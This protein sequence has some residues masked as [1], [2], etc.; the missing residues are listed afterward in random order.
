MSHL[1]RSRK[2]VMIAPRS[3]PPPPTLATIASTKMDPKLFAV[4]YK[5]SESD[6]HQYFQTFDDPQV[7]LEEGCPKEVEDREE[8]WVWL[9]S[10]FQEPHN[11]KAKANKISWE[12]KT[13]IHHS[14]SKPFS[15]R[16]KAW[17]QRGSKFLEI[18]IFADVYIRLRDKLVESLHATMMENT[19]GIE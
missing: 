16:M 9:C 13:F 17:P 19:I 5:Q 15:Y 18:D 3:I 6:L 12:K 8:N 11:V 14:S 2:A 1:I 7:A 4:W 10:H